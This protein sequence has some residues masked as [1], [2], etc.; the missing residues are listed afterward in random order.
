M[1]TGRQTFRE[2]PAVFDATGSRPVAPI[3]LNADVPLD[4]E[5]T[6]AKAIDKDRR[7]RYQSA[8]EMR[9]DLQRLKRSRE[10]SRITAAS[11]DVPVSRSGTR[12]PSASHV[13][14]QPVPP[15]A[16]GPVRSTRWAWLVAAGGAICVLAAGI[17]FVQTGSRATSVVLA[18]DTTAQASALNNASSTQTPV[19]ADSAAQ[20]RP[21][22][23]AP[24]SRGHVAHRVIGTQA[25]AGPVKFYAK[26]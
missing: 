17:F 8:S 10:S 16:P 7:L 20:C 21:I 13:A 22:D 14:V 2:H 9:T 23:I 11:S 18:P 1:A 24:L 4:L 15:V 19:V 3:E 12:W 6:I 25:S 5:R 26:L